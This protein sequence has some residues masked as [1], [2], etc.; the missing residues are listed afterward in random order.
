MTAGSIKLENQSG[1]EPSI[2]RAASRRMAWKE[3][4]QNAPLLVIFVA[5]LIIALASVTFAQTPA[6]A[7]SDA[8]FWFPIIWSFINVFALTI[9]GFL[10]APEKENRTAQ[11][12][13][14]LPITSGFVVRNKIFIGAVT[15][16][17]F[18]GIGV[19]LQLFEVFGLGNRFQWPL[20]YQNISSSF[21]LMGWA[22]V[23]VVV[24]VEFFLLGV[25]CSLFIKRTIFAVVIAAGGFLFIWMLPPLIISWIPTR[26]SSQDWTEWFS[27]IAFVLIKC[28]IY[29]GILT[30]LIY[31][32]R[33][34]LG[35]SPQIKP[36]RIANHSDFVEST[37]IDAPVLKNVS[38]KPASGR[39]YSSLIWQ[40]FRQY[41]SVLIWSLLAGA[42]FALVAGLLLLDGTP[43][44]SSNAIV[45]CCLSLTVILIVGSFYCFSRDQQDRSYRFFQQH[46]ERGRKL[47]FSRL[48][49][50]ALLSTACGLMLFVCMFLFDLSVIRTYRGADFPAI[51]FPSLP[52]LT[53][54]AAFSIGQ[55]CSMFIRSSVFGFV[56]MVIM[57]AVGV[58]WFAWLSY[59]GENVWLFFC[60]VLIGLIA[61][62]W[63]RAPR[64]LADGRRMSDWGLPWL[65]L[66][67]IS[68]STFGAFAVNRVASVPDTDWSLDRLQSSFLAVGPQGHPPGLKRF[69]L[70]NEASEISQIAP[71]AASVMGYRHYLFSTTGLEAKQNLENFIKENEESLDLIHEANK[72]MGG[73][74]VLE[75]HSSLR[76]REQVNKLRV[77]MAAEASLAELDGDLELA[78]EHWL[79][80]K[81]FDEE[82]PVDST[83]P[84][85]ETLIG[86]WSELP[87]QSPE[88][89]KRAIDSLEMNIDDW[90]QQRIRKTLLAHVDFDNWFTQFE[91]GAPANR[92]SGMPYGVGLAD[93]PSHLMPWEV[94]RSKRIA[95][96]RIA[97]SLRWSPIFRELAT[98]ADTNFGAS[99]GTDYVLSLERFANGWVPQV[100]NGPNLFDVGGFGT[101]LEALNVLKEIQT[102]RYIRIRM[103]LRA[104]QLEHGELPA[105][106]AE[107]VPEHFDRLPVDVFYGR[108]F[109][110]SPSGK[111]VQVGWGL[112]IHRGSIYGATPS[113]E[114]SNTKESFTLNEEAAR[115]MIPANT[116]FLL[117]WFAFD[118]DSRCRYR[119]QDPEL[120]LITGE[121]Y[122]LSDPRQLLCRTPF[123]DSYQL[124]WD[125]GA[126]VASESQD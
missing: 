43:S 4:R 88:L 31:G 98:K 72:E 118:S 60:P 97:R 85:I 9:G 84:S 105:R 23:G 61:I 59:L 95:N 36:D 99:N 7:A 1:L 122:D 75:P 123:Y 32:G 63:W 3:V 8:T 66:G 91:N 76:R 44:S 64:W 113:S 67:L 24:P 49:P 46:V 28:F 108:E 119:Y 79:Q 45:W 53:V 73:I 55:F 34:W 54:L 100:F 96:F 81:R 80:L 125:G 65:T 39:I 78:L 71:S 21:E 94:E 107:L 112:P 58:C 62:T 52:I 35:N 101:W 30:G 25:L 5:V 6:Q 11:M 103:A 114:L 124:D 2:Q 19:L 16:L 68:I 20:W 12:L 110:Y 33:R 126:A 42:P 87:G 86:R 74:E 111:D 17:A 41:R 121:C 38:R 57:S 83:Q 115:R 40:S 82:Y 26:F 77:L 56:A 10:F 47:W 104:Y 48:I 27:V 13:C 70:L 50:A 14:Q 51:R 117:P 92:Q 93:W 69:R 18:V 15:V 102:S 120:G 29:A 37:L 106:L 116:P 90:N 109:F 89:I 22:T